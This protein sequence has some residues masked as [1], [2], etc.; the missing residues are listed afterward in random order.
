MLINGNYRRLWLGQTISVVGDEVFDTTLL[1]WVGSVLLAGRAYAPAVSSTVLVI[2]S[3]VIIGLGPVAGVFVDRW[4]KQRTMMRTDLIRAGLVGLLI[5]VSL[6]ARHLP[7]GVTIAIIGVIV[8]GTTAASQF[9]GPARMVMIADIVPA[10]HQGRASSYLQSA[11][12]LAGIVGPPL[13]APLLVGVGVP[14]AIAIDA[15]S[16]LL[17]YSLIRAI[18]VPVA[19]PAAP[20]SGERT[21]RRDLVEGLRYMVRE[22]IVRAVLVTAVVVN[23]GLGT[24]IAL[25]LYFVSENLHAAAKWFGLLNGAFAVGVLGGA[26][27]GGVLGDRLGNVRVVTAGLAGMGLMFAVYSRLGSVWPALPVLALV[28]FFLG[29]LNAAIVPVVLAAVPRE[30]LGRVMAVITPANRLGFIV[31]VG[32]SSLLVSTVLRGLDWHVLGLRFGRIDVTFFVGGLVSMVSAAYFASAARG[33][34]TAPA[35]ADPVSA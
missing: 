20:V 31:S 19:E 33:L 23:L 15:V 10:E 9:F 11:G 22:P 25:D 13:A 26:S 34:G 17:S 35:V 12:A 30:F 24:I 8:A 6:E 2:T 28:G 4:S 18:R 5:V 7:L 1:L 27:I 29:A 14:W 21:L 32:V 3:A 16:F